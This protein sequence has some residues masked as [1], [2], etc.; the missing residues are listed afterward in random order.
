MRTLLLIFA[1]ALCLPAF[2]DRVPPAPD[3]CPQGSTGDTGHEGPHCIP[4]DCTTDTDCKGG[5]VCKEQPL[6]MEEQ[7]LS[8]G[9]SP[10]K[11]KYIFVYSTCEAGAKCSNN[12]ATCTAGKRCVA[13][14]AS[15]E[16]PKDPPSTSATKTN[17]P[18]A[19]KGSCSISPVGQGSAPLCLLLFSLLCLQGAK[20]REEM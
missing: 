17:P 4:L 15:K 13:P 18:A 2:A 19:N 5:K 10:E 11:R 6:C 1:L 3:D 7:M 20:R 12:V 8:P 9:D 14:S 16:P